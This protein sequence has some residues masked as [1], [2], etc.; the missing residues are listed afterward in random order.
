MVLQTTFEQSQKWSLIRCTLGVENE[1]KN[2]LNFQNKAFNGENI[3]TLGDLNS[4][5]S[6]YFEHKAQLLMAYNRSLF[7]VFHETNRSFVRRRMR[8]LTNR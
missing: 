8:S 7:S 3:L 1:E 5:I 6:L 2:S 4:G